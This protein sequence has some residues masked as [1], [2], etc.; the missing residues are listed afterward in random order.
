MKNILLILLIFNIHTGCSYQPA[1]YNCDE[2]FPKKLGELFGYMDSTGKWIIPPKFT[3]ASPFEGGYAVVSKDSKVYLINCKGKKILSGFNDILSN[4][5]NNRILVKTGEKK[6]FVDITGKFITP[7]WDDVK[8]YSCGLSL[9][10]Q[11]N[12]YGFMDTTGN[13]A[14]PVEYTSANS[15]TPNGRAIVKKDYMYGVID[16]KGNEIVPVSYRYIEYQHPCNLYLVKTNKGQ[17]G[18]LTEDGGIEVPFLDYHIWDCPRGDV[19]LT[20][21]GKLKFFMINKQGNIISG[22]Y[23]YIMTRVDYGDL[24]PAKRKPLA[25]FLDF[26]GKEIIPFIYNTAFPFYEDRAVV[27]KGGKYGYINPAGE[28]VIPPRF[29]RAE[30]YVNGIAKVQINS[31]YGLI[32]RDGKKLTDF[33]YSELEDFNEGLATVQKGEKWGFIDTSGQLVI[34]C[35]FDGVLPFEYGTA[36]VLLDNYE[37]YINRKGERVTEKV[38]ATIDE[39]TRIGIEYIN[40]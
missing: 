4:N 37:F 7:V 33:I 20:D 19:M 5:I 14:I 2:L 12:M 23:D 16:T 21:N 26:S 35:R 10:K 22:E 3:N 17:S 25:G 8:P 32:D 15:F 38:K 34:P 36:K 28:E 6:G 24:I 40:D 11:D 39:F 30:G 27:G 9:V 31:L 18:F 29:D 13:I 1:G